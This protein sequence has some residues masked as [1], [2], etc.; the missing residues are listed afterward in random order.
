MAHP[1]A[2]AERTEIRRISDWSPERLFLALEG[3]LP[4]PTQ[5]FLKIEGLNGAGSIKL[6]AAKGMLDEAERTGALRR[7]DTIIESSSGNLGIALALLAAERGYRLIC[8]VDPNASASH[9]KA[10]RAYGAEIVRVTELDANG[11]YLQSRIRY[12]TN[13]LRSEPHLFWPNQYANP[14]NTRAHVQ[15]TAHFLW[16]SFD[17][18]DYLFVGCGTSGTL[19]GCAEYFARYSPKTT[20]VGVDSVGSVTFDGLAATRRIPGLGASRRP[21]LF[22]PE[23]VHRLVKVSEQAAVE[24]CRAAVQRWGLLAGGSTGSI[25]AAMHACRDEIAAGSVVV[26]ISPDLGERYLDM[27]YDDDWVLETFGEARS[28]RLEQT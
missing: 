22:K 23:H 16:E 28:L 4:A 6:T 12:I 5:A 10:M 7:G 14:A 13:R 21:E 27:F 2:R 26:G 15:R 11:G 3:H 8:V 20:L 24:Q 25:L 9:V 19:M 17:Q 18:I 1:R